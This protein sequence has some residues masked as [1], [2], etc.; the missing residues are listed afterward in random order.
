M[1]SEKALQ[2]A[3]ELARLI[4]RVRRLELPQLLDSLR[5]ESS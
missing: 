1:P 3:T 5:Q 2:H 4:G